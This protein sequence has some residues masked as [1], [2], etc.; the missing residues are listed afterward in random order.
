MA[1]SKLTKILY[2]QMTKLKLLDIDG[3]E[4][5]FR[6]EKSPFDGLEDPDDFAAD[7]REEFSVIGLIFPKSEIYGERSY[8]IELKLTREYPME[9]PVVRFLT[10]IFHLNVE[11]NGKT[12]FK[13]LMEK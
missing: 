8:R 12:K 13:K 3:A 2:G 9:P 6:L 7:K 10:T 11:E 5:R 4:G 1:S